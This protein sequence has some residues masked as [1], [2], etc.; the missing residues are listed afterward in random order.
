MH[1]T[2]EEHIKRFHERV[3]NVIADEISDLAKECDEAIESKNIDLIQE[4][5]LKVSTF[6]RESNNIPTDMQLE[7]FTANLYS[8]L[9]KNPI[10]DEVNSYSEK[11]IFTL[12]KIVEIYESNYDF[13]EDD[14][15]EVDDETFVA[16]YIAMRTYTNLGVAIC[17]VGRYIEGIHSYQKA[18]LIRDDFAMASLNLSGALFEYGYLNIKDYEQGYYFHSAYYYYQQMLRHRRNLEDVAY[19]EH[20]KKRYL[21]RFHASFISEYLQKPL[22]LPDFEISKP[23]EVKYR[24]HMGFSGL[25]LEPCL[26]I[27]H[28]P[29]FLVDSLSLP[30]EPGINAKQD[31]FIGLFNLLKQEYISA[32]YLWYITTTTDG[33]EL[34]DDFAD[35]QK[36]IVDI[37][38]KYILSVRENLLRSAFRG[39]YSLF[40]KIGLFI[41]YYFDVGLEGNRIS[42]KNIWKEHV[43]P[44]GK[45]LI[46]KPLDL[47]SNLMLKSIYWLQKDLYE[48]ESVNLT[49]PS[50]IRMFEMRNDME[51]NCLLSVLDFPTREVTFSKFTTP[52]QIG[53]YTQ[54]LLLL[55]R[56]CLI[57]LTLAINISERRR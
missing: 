30:L 12:R 9:R 34:F 50:A 46:K 47:D 27:L 52:Y 39:V 5:I 40:D 21:E 4:K 15:I 57:Y 38:D 19:V 24:L 32:R 56:E 2:L 49:S 55:A 14:G 54:R 31:E 17:A 11:E 28:D 43:G 23:E 3:D 35:E 53:D 42:F 36:D 10:N 33:E 37:G 41:N 7:Y 48:E 51:H 18:L 13:P 20:F 8:A 26:D 45:N 6:F 1:T 44:K 16:N 29:C 25:F 22:S